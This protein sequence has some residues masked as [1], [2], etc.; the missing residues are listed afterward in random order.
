MTTNA[1][2]SLGISGAISA[3]YHVER[4][5]GQGGMSSVYLADDPKHDR[6]VALKVMR[7]DV[8]VPLGEERFA[9]EIKVTAG[10][11][12]PNI[13]PL[14]D[15]GEADGQVFYVMPFVAGE[16]LRDRMKREGRL[17][18]VDSLR[19]AREVADALAYAHERGVIH[20]DIKP[21]NVLLSAGHAIVADFGIARAMPAAGEQS[22]TQTGVTIGTPT[23]M[24]PEQLLGEP[25]DGRADVY[26]LGCVLFEMISGRVPFH[27]ATAV[28]MLASKLTGAL[29][30]V[31]DF[32]PDVS[33]QVIDLI[34]RML[35][36]E[37]ADRYQTAAELMEALDVVI[38]A[39]RG[40]STPARVEAPAASAARQT[41]AIAVLA[42][43]S[44]SP[45]A[46]DEHLGD[47]LSEELMHALARIPGLRVVARTSAFA[48]KN[49]TV[50]VREIGKRLSVRRV[51]EGSVRRAGDRLRITAKLIDAET[52][53]EIWS[54]RFDRRLEDV[55]DVEDEIAA[56]LVRVLR[57]TLATG[58]E[59]LPTSAVKISTTT[60]FTAYEEYLKG[61]AAW[62]LRTEDGLRRSVEHLERALEIDPRFAL[63]HAALADSLV[64][65]GLYGMG[66]PADT[67]PQDRDAAERALALA[68]DSAEARTA[69]ACVTALYDWD[70]P[71][72][73]EGFRRAIAANA[74]YPTAH[75]WY[76]A[77]CLVPQGRFDEAHESLRVARDLDPLSPAVAVSIVA[78]DYYARRYDVAIRAAD[79]MLRGSDQFAMAHYFRGLALEQQ[80]R[81][82][83]AIRSLERASS[84]SASAEILTALAHA[85]AVAGDEAAA[86]AILDRLAQHARVRY[87]SP[88]L[89]AQIES[90]LGH[91]DR[92]LELLRAGRSDRS[93]DL[94]WIGV[95]PVFDSL[96]P[97]REFTEVLH[98]V[99]L[100]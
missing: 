47:G 63:A 100:S 69:V 24:S 87:V 22:M 40:A 76:A 91:T 51:V 28:A 97:H 39:V 21:E 78:T 31:T 67:M 59:R 81:I 86:R 57:D 83:D 72:A 94:I 27:G 46:A 61:R 56:A 77:N 15:S 38:H 90:A 35:A 44:M 2:N 73:E 58:A 29:P 41:N 66:A 80:G 6:K 79:E 70:F 88:V 26:A 12:H 34:E 30:A 19:I 17:P 37:S 60:S 7:R 65:L 13:L 3:R 43:T 32:G 5:L 68:S 89:M 45:D 49:T 55:F 10:L 16:S 11:S 95:R 33:P 53:L 75:Q 25:A 48:F 9:R 1:P 84:L 96:R 20:R 62:A 99:G 23:Y 18:L 4:E 54:E 36:R 74:Q 98:S 71:R 93:A 50:D 82:D 14:L 92:A 64:T 8:G 52:A 85:R 42:F